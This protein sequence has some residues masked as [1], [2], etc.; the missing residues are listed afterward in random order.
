MNPYWAMCQQAGV[1]PNH[2]G[3]LDDET[4]ATGS[5]G[6]SVNYL[7]RRGY[8]RVTFDARGTGRS[9]GDYTWLSEEQLR[10]FV[11]IAEYLATNLPNSNGV[12]GLT[13]MSYMGLDCLAA[14]RYIESTSP[15]K[16]LVTVACGG[17]PFRGM[18]NQG[19]IPTKFA[20]W[21]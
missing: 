10:D 4:T 20:D 7:V 18:F 5:G 19:G 3:D 6:K 2:I 21:Y 14:A 11:E 17:D 16:A 12:A 8:I 13:G 1:N 15:I 9:H